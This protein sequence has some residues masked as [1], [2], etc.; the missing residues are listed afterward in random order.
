M[1]ARAGLRAQAQAVGR[2]IRGAMPEPH[3][4]LFARL[5]LVLI[6]SVDAEGQPH[7]S[8]LAGP[9][10]F[11]HSP[12]PC[13]LTVDA[14]PHPC[15]PLADALHAGASVAL[16]GIEAHTRRRNRLNG[17][18]S[19]VSE[20]GFTVRVQQSFGNCPKYIQARRATF[21]PDRVGAVRWERMTQLDAEAARAIALADTFFIASAHPAHAAATSPAHGA[22]VSHRG[23]KPGFVRIVRDEDGR[24]VLAVPDFSGNGMF[25]TLGN[26]TTHP[27]A[28]LLFIDYERGDLLHVTADAELVWE[29]PELAA[30]AGAERLLRL[31]VR[32]ALR[33]HAAL[34]LHWSTPERSPSSCSSNTRPGR[35]VPRADP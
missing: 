35:E 7:A 34:A 26:L 29:G 33:M 15:D 31:R 28:G 17:L 3:R 10:G 27:R 4:E 32:A 16:L 12:D 25:N 11:L 20:R 8:A 6:G 2:A 18:V 1:Q 19:A 5:P 14:W 23:G 9:P 21:H 13:L 22:D 24:D 30:F